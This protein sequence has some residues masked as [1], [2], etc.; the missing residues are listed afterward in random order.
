MIKL[1]ALLLYGPKDL[2]LENIKDPSPKDEWVLIRV[3]RVGI[4]GTDKAFYKG[5]YKPGKIPIIAGHEIAGE[6]VDVGNKVSKD[7][8]GRRATTEINIPC[9]RCWYCTHG[10]YT[11]C[12]YREVIGITIDGG[13]A[14]YVLTRSDVIH[15]V[16]ELSYEEAAFIEPLA[17]VIEMIE[18][19]PPK[20]L[21]DVAVIGSGA[22][23][24]LAIQVLKLMRPR[25]I[26]VITRKDS[27]KKRLALELGADETIDLEEIYDYVKKNT[28]EGSGF[29]YVVEASGD[30]SAL[31]LAINITRPRGVVAAKST[32]GVYTTF[33]YT[34]AI[35][36]ELRIIGSR[37]GPFE[38][39]IDLLRMKLVK[40]SKLVTGVYSLEEGRKAFE[41]S[42]EREHIKIHLEP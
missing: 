26:I 41:K 18:M 35:V 12:P 29:D 7:L 5:T 8:V 4:C 24:L 37:C 40:I 30:P 3:R 19:E 22:I 17:A 28:R 9:R 39:A 33:D 6:I 31:D 36:K 16:D 10:M 27:P 25:K 34:K 2:R 14:E 20:P 1:R 42:F 13:M 32:H 15:I 21:S 11:H 38:K 23:G